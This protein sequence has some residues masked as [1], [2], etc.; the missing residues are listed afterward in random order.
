MER[1]SYPDPKKR[2]GQH[3]LYDKK[4][5]RKIID[6]ADL[7]EG[8]NVLEIGPGRGHMT[9]MLAALGVNLTAVEIDTD[10]VT[11]PLAE[12]CAVRK[13][14]IINK[15]ALEL[16]PSTLFGGDEDYKLISNLPYNVG[17]RILRKFLS[18]TCPPRLSVVMLQKEVAE[19]ITTASGKLGIS[20]AF[21][22]AFVEPSI[23][24][25]VKPS[26]FRPPP[27]V[28]SS[29]IR[30]SRLDIP[31]ISSDKVESYFQFIISGFSSPRKQIRNSLAHGLKLAPSHINKM[32]IDSNIDPIRRPETITVAEWVILFG[33]VS[34]LK[35]SS[36]S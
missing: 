21:L 26:S 31:L 2:L 20:G 1:T 5:I 23:L 17:G 16:D 33:R 35:D 10:L 29:V 25:T 18:G 28:M 3:F 11:G 34:A 6:R 27:K 36:V 8:E 15:D 7:L 14:E 13:F 32:L 4:V 12:V 24:F 9:S 30:L 19:N 22:G